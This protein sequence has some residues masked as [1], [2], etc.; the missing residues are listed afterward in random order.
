[1]EFKA[2]V[3][4]QKIVLAGKVRHQIAISGKVTDVQTNKVIGGALVA[5]KD[6]PEAFKTW[7]ETRK[8]RFGDQWEIMDKRPARVKSAAD[9][10]LHFL[11]LPDGEY[12]LAAKLPGSGS[13]YDAAEVQATVSTDTAGNITMAVADIALPPTSIKGKITG[14]DNE[15]VLL[16]EVALSEFDPNR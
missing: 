2:K 12:T 8:K 11:N 13:R 16:A 7:L 6:G 5:I 14:K 10:H 1:M 3:P 9:G 4:G 15:P